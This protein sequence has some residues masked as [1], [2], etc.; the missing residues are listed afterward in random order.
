VVKKTHEL[1]LEGDTRTEADDH[2]HHVRVQAA[3]DL[4]PGAEV[5][6]TVQYRPN[7]NAPFKSEIVDLTGGDAPERRLLF[8]DLEKLPAPKQLFERIKAWWRQFSARPNY[9]AYLMAAALVVYLMLRLIRLSDFPIFF[10]TD[11][12]IHTMLA[13]SLLKNGFSSADGE[14]LPTFFKSGETLNA[15]FPVY[16]HLLPVLLGVRSVLATRLVSVITTLLAAAGLGMIYSRVHSPRRGWLAVLI[17]SIVPAW[18]YHSRTAFETVIAVSFYTLFLLGY[19]EYRD[20]NLRWLYAAITGAALAFYSYSPARV[21]V[22]FTAFIMLIS[23]FK[24]HWNN[25]KNLWKPLLFFV[26]ITLPYFR[27]V[28]LHPVE[29]QHHL[30][31]LRSYWVRN[32]P[33]SWKIWQL[34]TT[35]VQGLNP[36]YWF[37]PNSIDLERHIMRGMGHLGWYFLPFFIGGVVIGIKNWKNSGYRLMLFSLLAAPSGAAVAEIGITRAQFMVIPAAFF[38]TI[39]IEYSIEWLKKRI[40]T[41]RAIETPVFLLLALVNF[42]FLDNVLTHGPTWF[43]DYGLNG[44]QYGARQVFG[45][46]KEI[47]QTN[48]TVPIVLTPEWANGTDTLSNFFLEGLPPIELAGYKAY[49]DELKDF[50][51]KT[52]FIMTPDDLT[53]IISSGKFEPL[54]IVDVIFYPNGKPGFYFAH[55][56]YNQSARLAFNQDMEKRDDLQGAS[57]TLHDEVVSMASSILDMGNLPQ[58][59]DNDPATLIRTKEANPL[60]IELVFSQPKVIHDISV[61]IGGSPTEVAAYVLPQGSTTPYASSVTVGSSTEVRRINVPIRQDKPVT[62]IRL[63]IRSILDSTPSHVHLW[64][65]ELK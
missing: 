56:K 40:K 6:I 21:V 46:I 36:Y 13:D 3:V 34:F 32:E 65:L 22:A 55:M 23:D 29:N 49:I 2:T 18:F 11:E 57:F 52:I 28:Y 5:R 48:P 42:L 61:R 15:G 37:F 24:Y 35:Y 12:A 53:N 30:E 7:E 44:L 51:E 33:L 62:Q 25:R 16:M 31:L 41:T 64:D 45:R 4:P 8:F 47:R 19:I 43:D 14:F 59:F 38:I 39:G 10:F 60:V 63:E 50:N 1:P 20:G 9:S 26:V 54:K 17:L 27:Y 58:L